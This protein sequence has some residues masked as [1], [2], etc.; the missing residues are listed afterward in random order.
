MLGRSPIHTYIRCNSKSIACTN[1]FVYNQY[2][3]TTVLYKVRITMKTYGLIYAPSYALLLGSL[4]IWPWNVGSTTEFLSYISTSQRICCNNLWSKVQQ[5]QR[6]WMTAQRRDTHNNRAAN[7]SKHE[8]HS[9]T[10]RWSICGPINTPSPNKAQQARSVMTSRIYGVV[11]HVICIH[12]PSHL[13]LDDT[14][15]FQVRWSTYLMRTALP[16]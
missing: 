9:S 16:H 3:T 2:A 11:Y 4:S 12:P 8:M 15:R 14:P 6:S 7:H 13:H 1:N 5:Q 10:R